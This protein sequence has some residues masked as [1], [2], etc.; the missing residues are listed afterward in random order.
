MSAWISVRAKRCHMSSLPD[1]SS[2]TLNPHG[3]A[4]SGV[5]CVPLG[6]YVPQTTPRALTPSRGLLA[7]DVGRDGKCLFHCISKLHNRTFGQYKTTVQVIEDVRAYLALKWELISASHGEKS[8]K[9]TYLRSVGVRW[10]GP[11]EID[12]ACELYRVNIFEWVSIDAGRP[13]EQALNSAVLSARYHPAFGTKEQLKALPAW[14][15]FW[16]NNHF[17]YLEKTTSKRIHDAAAQAGAPVER[18]KKPARKAPNMNDQLRQLAAERAERAERERAAPAVEDVC[19]TGPIPDPG[20]EATMR[21]I[22]EL[23]AQEEQAE[24]DAALARQLAYAL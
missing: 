5:Y 24:R 19:Y 18:P 11:L 2:L 15:I 9:A 1:L 13:D 20:D 17:R 14:D 23:V 12:A 4:R 3:D 16:N 10:G 8:D 7:P 6:I 22:R 21:L